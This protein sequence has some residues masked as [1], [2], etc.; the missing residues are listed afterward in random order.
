MKKKN[1]DPVLLTRPRTY[2]V[3]ILY[4]SV[5]KT[6][7]FTPANKNIALFPS[8]WSEVGAGNLEIAKRKA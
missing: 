2:T 4:G 8:N 5:E 3:H 1:T 6:E 7:Q